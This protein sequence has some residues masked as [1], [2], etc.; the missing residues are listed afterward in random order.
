VYQ[1]AK[2]V[3]DNY[4]PL[5][6][7]LE[8][9]EH[10][11][12]RL[13]IYTEIPPTPTMGELIFKIMVELLSTLASATKELNQGRSSKSILVDIWYNSA[14]RRGVHTRD[15]W[16][17]QGYRSSLTKARSPHLQP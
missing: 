14:L 11:L 1:A 16:R 3:V 5:I 12:Q 9:I 13:D 10:F 15:F 6:Y 8:A 4:D 17:R 7:L 2:G